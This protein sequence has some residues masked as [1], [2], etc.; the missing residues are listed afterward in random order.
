M[1]KGAH[2]HSK[3]GTGESCM[4]VGRPTSTT[5]LIERTRER[6][7]KESQPMP[8]PTVKTE[9]NLGPRTRLLARELEKRR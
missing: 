3:A 2:H 9:T 1:L 5:T 6:L 7:I 8:P 4:M